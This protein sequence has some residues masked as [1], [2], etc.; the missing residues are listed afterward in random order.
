MLTIGYV[1]INNIPAWWRGSSAGIS[2]PSA[3]QIA[4]AEKSRAEQAASAEAEAEAKRRADEQAKADEAEAKR[5]LVAEAKRK[6]DEDRYPA[7]SVTPGSGRRQL[8]AARRIIDEYNAKA[9][10]ILKEMALSVTPGSGKT[11]RDRLADDAAAQPFSNAPGTSS[12]SIKP[13][14]CAPRWWWCRPTHSQWDRR[15][16]R[17]TAILEKY[18][19]A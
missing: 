8:D 9:E 16:V 17:R 3:S 18:R 2:D 19:C 10:A 11:F 1:G 12:T 4:M 6:A 15:R 5:Q 13:C 7:L 14:H